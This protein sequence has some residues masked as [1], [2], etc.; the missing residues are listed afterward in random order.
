[1]TD[2]SHVEIL[3]KGVMEWNTWRE[4]HPKVKPNLR[5]INFYQ[6]FSKSFY[7]LPSF[8]GYNFSNT[9]FHMSSFR[10]AIFTNC[11][12]DG[13]AIGGSDL[14]DGYF[15]SCSFDN[16]IM[17]VTG[18]GNATFK[19]CVFINSDLSYCSARETSFK[20]SKFINTALEHMSFVST[21][22]SNTQIENC[23]VYGISS[24]DLK[25]D[26]SHQKNLV[27]TQMDQ[28]T[29]TV[30]NIEL[31]QFIYLIINNKR[32]RDVIDTITSKVVLILG[33][34]SPERK[35]ILDTLKDEIRNYNYVP[36]LLD[37]KKPSS[38]NLTETIFT[39][40]HMSKF[41][42]ADISDPRSIGHELSA[43]IPR[44]QS[45][46]FYPLI[47]EG[48]TEYSKLEEFSSLHW[49]KPVQRYDGDNILQILN[50]IIENESKSLE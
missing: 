9:D 12:F 39:L 24:W 13:S 5:N 8:D 15:S 3:K 7:D 31:A 40:A 26:N 18:I 25:L 42:I 20:G 28:P 37:F 2:E 1:M 30:D 38:R 29:I 46:N 41:I 10:N 6:E 36:V 21:D 17:R 50:G 45:V 44:L 19:D 23:F 32:L 47:V 14:V 33:N 43:I 34:F 11:R 35:K 27:I 49:M 48:E 4:D 16:V 22:F